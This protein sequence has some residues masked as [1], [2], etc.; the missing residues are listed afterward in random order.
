LVEGFGDE[1]VE[2]MERGGFWVE[3]VRISD[4]MTWQEEGLGEFVQ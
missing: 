3:R 1:R 2:D 4:T